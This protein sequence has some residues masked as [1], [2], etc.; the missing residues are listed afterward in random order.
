MEALYDRIGS[1]YAIG[2]RTDPIISSYIF[3][4]LADSDSIVNIG[5]GA[6]S[7]EPSGKNLVAV[8]PS[9]TMISQRSSGACQVKQAFAESLPFKDGSFSHSMTVLSMHHWS[10][11]KSAFEE[12]KRVTTKRFIAVTWNPDSDPYWLTQ[13]YFPEIHDIDRL[14]FP[15]LDELTSAFPGIRFYPLAIPADCV[16]GFTAAYWARPHAYLNLEVRSGMS[17]FNKIENLASGLEKLSMDLNS[18]CWENRNARLR[19][20]DQL[21]V[22][23]TVAVWDT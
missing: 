5:A 14:L 21:D 11:R 18:G 10:D 17:T 9:I 19:P 3:Q 2:R 16:D 15:S 7:Y 6:G 4:F 8:E 1:N 13:E 12:V 22:G 23:Y 20:L